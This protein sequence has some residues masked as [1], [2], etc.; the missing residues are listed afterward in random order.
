MIYSGEDY[1]AIEYAV[2]IAASAVV[3]GATSY[4][5]SKATSSLSYFADADF[6]LNNFYAFASSGPKIG[7]MLPNGVV[8]E[9]ASHLLL[10]GTVVGT[11]FGLAGSIFQDISEKSRVAWRLYELGLNPWDSFRYAFFRRNT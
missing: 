3:G 4:L 1:S 8:N 2:T 6:F 7:P 9:L 5:F 10:R 11:I